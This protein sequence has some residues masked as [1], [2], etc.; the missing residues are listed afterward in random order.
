MCKASADNVSELI[1][2]SRA[3]LLFAELTAV[4]VREVARPSPVLMGRWRED[5]TKEL[6]IIVMM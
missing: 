1:A 3:E 4:E 6:G 5:R 2:P